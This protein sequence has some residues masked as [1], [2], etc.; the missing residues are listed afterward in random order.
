[1]IHALN[2]GNGK[3]LT[4]DALII[5]QGILDEAEI[6]NYTHFVIKLK[7]K[8]PF[9]IITSGR[10]RPPTLPYGIKF[11]PF[12]V[13]EGFLIKNYPEKPLL[14]KILMRIV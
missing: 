7:D 12:S 4:L 3:K 10:G 14:C 5:H 8:V 1:M 6:S 9:V 2:K 13:I 11:L